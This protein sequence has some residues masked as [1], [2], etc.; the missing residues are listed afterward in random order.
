LHIGGAEKRGENEEEQERRRRIRRHK[1]R[2]D[3]SSGL[4]KLVECVES[5]C[6]EECETAQHCH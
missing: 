4:Q 5:H 3:T 6:E 1:I 2:Q